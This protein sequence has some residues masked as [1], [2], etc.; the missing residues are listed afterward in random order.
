MFKL[1]GTANADGTVNLAVASSDAVEVTAEDGATTK[2]YTVT[3]V[4]AEAATPR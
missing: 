1:N 4:R 3:V 2:T